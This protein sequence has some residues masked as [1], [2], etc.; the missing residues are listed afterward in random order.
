MVVVNTA[1]Q[2]RRAADGEADSMRVMQD[3][4]ET[5]MNRFVSLGLVAIAGLPVAANASTVTFDW[6]QTG[7]TGTV[8]GA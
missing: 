4:T 7:G 3:D 8:K 5:S 2:D 1:C 6:V